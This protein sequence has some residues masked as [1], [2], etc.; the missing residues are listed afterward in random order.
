MKALPYGAPP[1]VVPRGVPVDRVRMT[2]KY[3]DLEAAKARGLPTARVQVRCRTCGGEG[4]GRVA[5][6]DWM[7]PCPSCFGQAWEWYDW[8]VDVAAV[9]DEE[10]WE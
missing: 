5:G 8:P 2:V 9:T 1:G 3:A 4:Y 6:Y 10:E 7:Q